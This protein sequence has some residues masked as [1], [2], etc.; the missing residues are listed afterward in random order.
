MLPVPIPPTGPNVPGDKAVPLEQGKTVVDRPRPELDPLGLPVGPFFFYPRAEID[1]AY[2]DNI[3]ASRSATKDDFITVLAPSFDLR[4]NFGTNALNLSAGA[5][6]SRYIT[7]SAFD[8]EDYFLKGDGRLDVDNVHDFHGALNFQRLHEDPGSPDV[9]GGAAEPV[10]Y[11][12][13]GATAGFEQTKLRVVY[14]AD[15]S[16]QREEYEAVP[17][18]GG[19]LIQESDRNNWAYELALRGGY[20]F[21]TGYQAFV[22]G[23][24]NMR[25][26]DHAALGAPGRNSHGY[27]AD[28]GTRIDLTG[29]T[30]VEAYVGYLDQIYDSNALGSV[31]GYDVGANVVWNVTELTS[32]SGKVERNVQDAPVS[33]VG[34]TA[35]PAYLHTAVGVRVDHELLRNLLLNGQLTFANDDFHGLNRTDDDYLAGVGAKYLLNRNFYLGATY[36]YEHRDSSGT[37]AV[38]Q[39]SRN[40]FMLRASTQ[41]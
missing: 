21:Q 14:S 36:T 11:S 6:I 13:Y 5:A 34:T 17:S 40:V 37:Q 10:H 18:V 2:N 32:V 20:E 19:G 41:F 28:V 8:T 15:L 4:S 3:F 29:V 22:R 35:S 24:V 9:A 1:E 39:F 31:S 16:A 26:Y 12:T 23:T 30:Y 27:R 7:H 25:D 33:V 38:N